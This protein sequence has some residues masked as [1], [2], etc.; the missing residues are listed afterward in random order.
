[1]TMVWE[2]AREEA[3]NLVERYGTNAPR[4]LCKRLGINVYE[5]NLPDGSS[6]MIVKRGGE[7]AEIFV[8]ANDPPVRRKFTLAHELGHYMERALVHDDDFSFRERR[9][10]DYDLHEFFADEFA[11]ALL[12]PEDE[13]LRLM[14]SGATNTG[15]AAH[16]DVSLSAVEKRRARLMK[17]RGA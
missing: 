14:D 11:G 8:E 5:V 15:L 3:K 17:T 12:M 13:F 7:D 9:G 6:G 10:M 1:M 16:F 4:E 2:A